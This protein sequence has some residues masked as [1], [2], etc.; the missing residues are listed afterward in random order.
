MA[1]P[2]RDPRVR[3]YV[4]PTRIVWRSPAPA[5][6]N[7][8]LLLSQTGHQ[9]GPAG[10]RCVLGHGA[11][12]LLDFGRELH[13]GVQ[14]VAHETTDNKPV[15]VRVRFGESAGEAMADPFPIH[16]HA[17]HDHRCALPWFGSAE[18]GNT[19]FRFVRIDVDDPGKEVR[20]VSV[21][22]VHLYRDLPWRGS[23]RCPD[24]R[25]NQIWRTGAYTTQLCLQDLLWDGIKRDRLVWIGDMHPETMVVATVF[26]SGDVV[27]HSLD[28]LRDAT[29]LPGWMNGISSYSLWWLLTQH[30]WWMYVGDAAYLEAQRGYLGGLAAQVLGCIG[31]DGGERLAEWRFLDWPTAGDDVAKHAGLQGLL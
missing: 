5:P 16:G 12:L 14:I 21:R 8:D 28:L 3:D 6:E 31:D 27:P 11:G 20:L 26:G 13:G 4:M 18:V 22:A 1:E 2:L 15:Q 30:T 24:E 17:I 19:G 29:P 9:V 7:P 10:P 25:L 23:F